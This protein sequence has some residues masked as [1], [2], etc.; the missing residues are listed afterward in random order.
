[1]TTKADI[2]GLGI[3][4]YQWAYNEKNPYETLPGGKISRIKALKSLDVPISLKP[5]QD[6]L[7]EDTIR[8][9][10]EKRIENRPTAKDLLKHPFLN[11]LSL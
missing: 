9:C 5:L 7:M 4:L 10:L 8:L 2:W 1:M 3:V 6:P 11:P